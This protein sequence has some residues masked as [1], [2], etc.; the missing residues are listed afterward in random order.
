M[1]NQQLA[2]YCEQAREGRP[3]PRQFIEDLNFVL[4]AYMTRLKE[5]LTDVDLFNISERHNRF[6]GWASEQLSRSC[7]RSP[8]GIDSAWLGMFQDDSNLSVKCQKV[9]ETN[10]YGRMFVD[11][12]Q[13][14][15]Q[16]V[17]GEILLDP[18]V[19]TELF[20]ASLGLQ[21]CFIVLECYLDII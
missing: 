7:H 3:D 13:E 15:L 20:M 11:I 10:E 8:A 17:K 12:A 19:P 18:Q 16:V 6:L 14:L 5:S 9:S 4:I 21:N 1:T 2:A